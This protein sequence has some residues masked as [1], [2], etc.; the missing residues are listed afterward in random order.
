MYY[1][2]VLYIYLFI[3]YFMASH[4]EVGTCAQEKLQEKR[5][6]VFAKIR[7]ENGDIRYGAKRLLR[8]LVDCSKSVKVVWFKK[9][10]V[11]VACCAICRYLQNEWMGT[12]RKTCSAIKGFIQQINLLYLYRTHVLD[13]PVRKY[14]TENI[15]P[16]LKSIDFVA[17]DHLGPSFYALEGLQEKFGCSHL[18]MRVILLFWR[19]IDGG[20]STDIDCSEVFFVSL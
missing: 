10:R 6:G 13:V 12:L 2:T 7:P 9:R 16:M 5:G 19:D 20:N 3:F 11:A 14:N 4:S 15:V 17:H 8:L 18:H 1:K